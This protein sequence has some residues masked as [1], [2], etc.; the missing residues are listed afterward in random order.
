M[1]KKKFFVI[2]IYNIN[3]TFQQIHSITFN[4]NN[5]RLATAIRLRFL[6][7]TFTAP[8]IVIAANLLTNN[9]T[10]WIRDKIICR[11]E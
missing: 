6:L 10:R 2:L 9:V 5:Y 8:K 4:K 1:L 11:V 7:Q 3:L